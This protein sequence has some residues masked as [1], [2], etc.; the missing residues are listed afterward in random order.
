[1]IVV[2]V[3]AKTGIAIR[4]AA[5]ELRAIWVAGNEYLQRA[6]PWAV[7]KTD[8]ERAADNRWMHRPPMDE[9]A[10]AR[11]YDPDTVEGRVFGA[12][13]GLAAV[14]A[15][16]PALHASA[17]VEV[18]VLDDPA[19]LG[20]TRR[21]PRGGRFVGLVNVSDR[22]ASVDAALVTGLD[23]VLSSDGPVRTE[24]GRAHLPP[25]SWAWLAEP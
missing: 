18:P 11:R 22:P 25:L 5:A 7:F 15:E 23:T 21:H 3:A 1:M 4:R 13:T 2:I 19:V 9:A 17:P 10:F 12:L 6:E 16:L 8:P 24:G 20:W 14:R